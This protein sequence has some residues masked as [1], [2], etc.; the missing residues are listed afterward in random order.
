MK[1][2][3]PLLPEVTVVTPDRASFPVWT[4][5][6]VPRVTSIESVGEAFAAVLE[7]GF[8]VLQENNL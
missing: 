2:M 5:G 3:V 8:V 4:R 1:H 6:G 7:D